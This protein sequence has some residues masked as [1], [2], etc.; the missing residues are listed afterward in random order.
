MGQ[1]VIWTERAKQDLLR[2]ISFIKRRWS[3][4]EVRQFLFRTDRTAR[5]LSQYPKMFRPI[6]TRGFR[7]ANVDKYNALI[8]RVLPE[9]V[10]I[11]SIWDMR[12]DPNSKPV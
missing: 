2:T 12:Q 1:K 8:Y 7:Q 4:R 3:E 6:G 10:E 9:C 5:Y 11:M